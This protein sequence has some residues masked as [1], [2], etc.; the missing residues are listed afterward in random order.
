MRNN[1]L[2]LVFVFSAHWLVAQSPNQA[3]VITNMNVETDWPNNTLTITYDVADTENDPLEMTVAF[4][5]DGGLHYNLTA[6]VPVTGDAGFPVAPGTGRSVSCDISALAGSPFAFTVRLVADDKQPFDLQQ[7]VDEVDSTRLR[8]DLEFVEGI[9]HRTTGLAH[10][11]E[12]RDSIGSHFV[13]LGF[14]KQEQPFPYGNATGRNIVGTL[15]GTGTAEKVV[16]VDA[17]YDTVNDAPGADD[18]GSGVVGFMEISRLLSRYPAKKTLRFIG[19]DMEEDGLRG[20]IDYVSNDIPANEQIE[21]V[22]NF[23]M[24][25]Y[26]SDQPNSQEVPAGFNIYFPAATAQIAANQYRG[27]FITNV[28]NSTCEPLALLFS[29]AA[30]QY[31]PDLKVITLVAPGNGTLFADLLRSDH[32]P[33]W[34]IS[35]PALMLTDGAD[36]RNNCYHTPQDMAAGK[37]S[38]TFMSNV[39]KATLAAAAQ[40]AEI[41]HGD[42]ATATFQGT[43]HTSDAPDCSFSIGTGGGQND[44]LHITVA[45]CPFTQAQ[46]DILDEKSTLLLSETLTLN[47]NIEYYDLPLPQLPVGMYFAKITWPGGMRTDKFIVRR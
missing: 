1:P 15:S 45:S 33:F 12:V 27:D 25:G 34:F 31:V 32:A 18:N 46:V 43:V 11:N 24:I 30:A 19:F 39:V 6:Q 17:H 13:N 37:L 22:F 2:L 28:A 42:W 14:A 20:S 7:L 47:D 40:L 16:I 21:G 44:I 26:Y 29:N 41:Q 4:S 9:R 35:E 38:F 8:D 5:N 10:L 3:P 36:F 23:E